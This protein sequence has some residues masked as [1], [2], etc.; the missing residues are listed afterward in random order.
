M[1]SKVINKLKYFNKVS[2][3]RTCCAILMIYA[4]I[5]KQD[6]SCYAHAD[7]LFNRFCLII[8]R[9]CC[10]KHERKE[11][12]YQSCQNKKGTCHKKGRCYST[13]RVFHCCTSLKNTNFRAL[14]SKK[15]FFKKMKKVQ[16][17]KVECIFCLDYC[18]NKKIM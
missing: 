4:V 18:R 3:I 16:R 6:A 12:R 1:L 5:E 7:K 2:S 17:L 11:R 10:V 15:I 8:F 9:D 13:S 14:R